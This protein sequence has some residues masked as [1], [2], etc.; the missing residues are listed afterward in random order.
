[1]TG[2]LWE[3]APGPFLVLTVVLGGGAAWMTGRAVAQ[4]WGSPAV[5][6]VYIAL[7]SFAV[8]FL[9]YALG[10]GALLSLHFLAVDY[11]YLLLVAGLGF[12][13]A[14]TTQMTTQYFWLYEKTSPLT[15]RAIADE[16]G[17]KN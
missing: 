14:R 8:R 13:V 12:Q 6:L 5:M 15:W 10:D 11:L 2:V 17:A 16:A 9:H 3:N 7:L 4:S 1:M